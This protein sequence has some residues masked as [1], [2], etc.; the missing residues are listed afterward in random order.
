MSDNSFQVYVNSVVRLAQTFIIKSDYIARKTNERLLQFNNHSA[1]LERPETWKYYMN[2]AGEYH[3]TDKVMRVISSDN[4]EEIEFNKTNLLRHRNTSR[5]YQFGTRQYEELL[6][7]YPGQEDVILGILY[8]VDKAAAIAARD[9]KILGYPKDLIEVN[10]YTLVEELQQWTD[11]YFKRYY[12]WQYTISDSLYYNLVMAMYGMNLIPAVMTFRLK[13]HKTIEA[14]SFYVSRY[15]A[16]NSKLGEYYPFMSLPQS[17]HM[18][19]NIR[20]YQRHA[21]MNQT[22]TKLIDALLTKRFIPIA[23]YSMRHTVLNQAEDIYPEVTFKRT[24]MTSVPSAGI[25]QF[26][27]TENFLIKEIPAAVDNDEEVLYVRDS[28]EQ[29]LKDSPSNVV[30]TKVLESAMIDYAGAVTYKLKD[31]QLAHWLYYSHL[32]MY[33]AVVNV[34][35]PKNG[36]RIVLTMKEAYI[37]ATYCLYRSRDII[38]VEVPLLV[39]QR[40]Q[41]SKIPSEADIKSIVDMKY[42]DDFS[43]NASHRFVREVEQMIS[44]DAFYTKTLEI[45]QS[46]NYQRNLIAF[47]EGMHQRGEVYKL[48][49]RYWADEYIRLVPQGQRYNEW[50]FAQNLDLETLNR[51]EFETL[52]ASILTRATGADLTTAPSLRNIQK[53]MIGSLRDLSSYTIQLVSKMA[54][55]ETVMLDFPSVR[56]GDQKVTAEAHERMIVGDMEILNQKVS[57]TNLEELPINIFADVLSHNVSGRTYHYMDLQNGPHPVNGGVNYHHKFRISSIEFSIVNKPDVSGTNLPPLLGMN[58]FIALTPEQKASFFDI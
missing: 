15:L 36:E 20:Y 28:V 54:D 29:F 53:A 50:L 42:V 16:S 41:R 55:E 47:Q 32:G 46:A 31:I 4:L 40:V 2:L 39:A 43:Y 7:S 11:V 10:E 8:P 51:G 6:K 12:N 13:R 3:P 33:T 9:H 18:Y 22:L 58:Y 49:S 38:P 5:D 30:Q 14:H 37:L 48:I 23:S 35:N 44:I 45:Y 17:M 25:P 24:D 26:V 27:N 1:D 34:A 19:R 57:A 21:G 52:F 56:I